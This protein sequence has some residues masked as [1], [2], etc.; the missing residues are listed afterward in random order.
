MGRWPTS[1]PV[2]LGERI[3]PLVAA[4]PVIRIGSKG[5]AGGKL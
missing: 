2:A 1:S 3:F 5:V 4:S